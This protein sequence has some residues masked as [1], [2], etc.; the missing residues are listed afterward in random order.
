MAPVM[1][2][3]SVILYLCTLAPYFISFSEHHLRL[4]QSTTY[5]YLLFVPLTDEEVA[6]GIT[7][8]GSL[9]CF[10]H[11]LSYLRS[12]RQRRSWHLS[13]IRCALGYSDRFVQFI[14]HLALDC[15]HCFKLTSFIS[16][17]RNKKN[18]KFNTGTGTKRNGIT[19]DPIPDYSVFIYA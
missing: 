14:Y 4:K 3:C 6:Y 2:H 5:L 11:A 9:A 1:T 19:E 10:S 13:R 8:L 7:D 12:T 18:L 15:I 17:Q 16:F